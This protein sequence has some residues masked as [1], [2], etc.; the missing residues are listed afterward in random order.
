MADLSPEAV[1]R[2]HRSIQAAPVFAEHAELIATLTP[3]LPTDQVL[4]AVVDADYALAGTYVIP[5]AELVDVVPGLEGDG[6]AMV[7][8]HRSDA[9]SV[10]YR[11]EEM[12]QI[13]E[14]R[15]ALITRLRAKQHL[16]PTPD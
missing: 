11:A 12:A 10:R 4:V 8:S 13:A 9:A 7:F 14:Q 5:R 3:D 2:A 15:I 6:W 1:A 16:P